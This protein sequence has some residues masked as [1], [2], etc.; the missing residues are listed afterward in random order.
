MGSQPSDFSHLN[1]DV[2]RLLAAEHA[3]PFAVLGMHAEPA[4]GAYSI[5]VFHPDARA[6]WAVLGRRSVALSPLAPGFFAGLVAPAGRRLPYRLKIETAD[7]VIACD[8]PY[9][10]GLIVSAE[11]AINL[12][13]GRCWHAH[14]VLGAHAMT[15][16]GVRGISFAVWAPM[17]KRVS[18]VGDWNDW[19]A[20]CRPMRFRH[21]IGVWE[22]F[23]PGLAPGAAY[24]FDILTADGRGL[25]KRDP[26]ARALSPVTAGAA[27][28]ALGC[29]EEWADAAWMANR[30]KEVGAQ[31]FAAIYPIS[32]GTSADSGPAPSIAKKTLARVQ[33]Q[34]GTHLWLMQPW[35]SQPDAAAPTPVSWLAPSAAWGGEAG[36]RHWINQAHAHGLGVLIDWPIDAFGDGPEGL[37]RFD[38]SAL[39]EHDDFERARA[40]NENLRRFNY[41]RYE[42][43]NFLLSAAL[44][45]LEDLHV[46][47]LA[48]R[49]VSETLGFR[50]AQ[51]ECA[52]VDAAG[53]DFVRRLTELVAARAPGAVVLSDAD[54]HWP[55][56]T[57][58]TWAGGL[59]CTRTAAP[60]WSGWLQ[61]GVSPTLAMLALPQ[62]SGIL[63][64][65][66]W[67]AQLV[68]GG[69]PDEAG[70]AALIMGMVP[71]W[72]VWPPI[73]PSAASIPCAPPNLSG[74]VRALNHAKPRGG[75][76]LLAHPAADQGLLTFTRGENMI[77]AANFS[78]TQT[79]ALC[80]AP[81]AGEY[82]VVARSHPSAGKP[83]AQL[84]AL[85]APD[86]ASGWALRL[87]LPPRSAAAA[88]RLG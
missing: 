18:L 35:T 1:D 10:F 76:E 45:W 30:G 39:Y 13:A 42:T 59:G 6:I 33:D 80:P 79:R 88:L 49:G 54:C 36:L 73:M 29:A 81:G 82:R 21:E 62:D 78:P 55:G 43:A 25:R 2:A 52:V 26:Y 37:A 69:G 38:G 63:P 56:V 46:D 12:K 75:V 64:F 85:P 3:D 60:Q 47:G 71:G 74:L 57:A 87:D 86:T 11:D 27:S 22:M 14:R 68:N 5:R 8:D 24:A 41:V 4:G 58:P 65:G 84:S 77:C 19:R 7:G 9:R 40:R 16:E 83:P 51:G 67:Q 61:D 66:A 28:A 34:G 53:V 44:F 50:A 17:A 48:L 32:P 31:Q 72:K 23:E 20:Q 15:L 70:L